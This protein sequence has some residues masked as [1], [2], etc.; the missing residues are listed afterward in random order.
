MVPFLEQFTI[1]NAHGLGGYVLCQLA[2]MGIKPAA[3]IFASGIFSDI[4]VILTQKY[5]P[6]AHMV[7][8]TEDQTGF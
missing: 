4:E 8:G 5:I 7:N 2:S 1:V 3:F 6:L